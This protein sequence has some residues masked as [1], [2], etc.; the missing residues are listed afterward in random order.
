MN[1]SIHQFKDIDLKSEKNSSSETSEANNTS[2]EEETEAENDQKNYD[3][4]EGNVES[5]HT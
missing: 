1:N 3:F 4:S 2:S 5:E